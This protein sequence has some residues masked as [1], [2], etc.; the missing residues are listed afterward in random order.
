MLDVVGGH[1]GVHGADEQ[2]EVLLR[3]IDLP[4]ISYMRWAAIVPWPS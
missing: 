3:A 4:L 2:S 1:R